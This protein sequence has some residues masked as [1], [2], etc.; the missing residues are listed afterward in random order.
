MPFPSLARAISVWLVVSS[1]LLAVIFLSAI[2]AQVQQEVS[3]EV[4]HRFAVGE[5]PMPSRIVRGQDGTLY[6]ATSGGGSFG[7]EYPLQD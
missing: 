6:G 3:V 1:V 2:A 5:G 4:V 7:C